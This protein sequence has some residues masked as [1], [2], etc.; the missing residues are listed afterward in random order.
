MIRFALTVLSIAALASA[1]VPTLAVTHTVNQ[2]G[3]TFVPDSL[4]IAP[5]DT[6]EWVWSIGIHTVTN[7]VHPDSADTGTLF[8]APLGVSDPLFSFTFTQ[9]GD[10]PYF[11]RPHLALGMIGVI[12]VDPLVAVG[13]QV[14]ALT[15]SRVK[16][17]Y[18]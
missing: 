12:R 10:V 18:R 7:G 11:C 15:W 5:G 1:P 8:D 4:I 16:N 17:L 9:P 2:D 14:E 3:L 6:V 13:A